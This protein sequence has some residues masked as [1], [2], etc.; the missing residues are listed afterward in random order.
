M[1]LPSYTDDPLT[2]A[3]CDMLLDKGDWVTAARIK[4]QKTV[5]EYNQRQERERIKREIAEE[6]LSRISVVVENGNAIKEIN[7][8]NKAIEQ[9]GE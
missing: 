9:L 8:L 5:A 6:V 2:D 4:A 1:N 7:L 3:I